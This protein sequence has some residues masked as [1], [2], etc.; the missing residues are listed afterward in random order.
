M[1][2]LGRKA[3]FAAACGVL[4]GAC[5]SID[6]K[7][8]AET[9][10][11]ARE[12]AAFT[13]STDAAASPG[14]T[15]QSAS[16]ENSPVIA[17]E[18]YQPAFHGL[19]VLQGGAGADAADA[20]ALDT[21]WVREGTTQEFSALLSPDSPTILALN[22]GRY[23]LVRA[24][25]GKLLAGPV[26]LDPGDVIYAGLILAQSKDGKT[27]IVAQDRAGSAR[28]ML[29]AQYPRQAPFLK[30]RLLASAQ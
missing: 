10:G 15:V 18:A 4:L 25:T 7:D 21:V 13:A 24:G 11:A 17:A 5:S 14:E 1:I 28:P 3:A 26:T 30:K 6:L 8:S 22:P 19:L 12:P 27:V 2:A 23:R 29:E 16:E 9:G 20:E